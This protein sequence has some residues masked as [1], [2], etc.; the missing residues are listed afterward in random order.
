MDRKFD[1]VVVTFF[2]F[3]CVFLKFYEYRKS[4]TFLCFAIIEDYA[5]PEYHLKNQGMKFKI[6]TILLLTLL[7][8]ASLFAQSNKKKI[9]IKGLVVDAD[10]N[11]VRDAAIIIDNEQTG[12]TTDQDGCYK[13][14]VNASA[15]NI[16]IYID[17]TVV[18]EEAINGRTNINFTLALK[19]HYRIDNQNNSGDDEDINIG[20]GT[21]KKK[22][23]TQPVSKIDAK[24][25]RYASYNNIY[26]MIRGE[27]PGVRVSGNKINIQGSFSIYGSTEPLFVVDGVPREYIDDI[28]PQMVASISV[29]KGASATIYGSRG[30]NGVILIYLKTAKDN[31]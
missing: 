5:L 17:S 12:K 2:I 31:K 7:T 19:I 1:I 26:D 25:N 6:V 30:A 21:V 3:V 13:I 16:G 24:K 29:L 28:P 11:P 8:G 9:T 10:Q 4:K 15:L 23:L 14:K 18:I 20:Y 27:V 22:D